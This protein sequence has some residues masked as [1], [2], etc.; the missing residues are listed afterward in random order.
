M[1]L[2]FILCESGVEAQVVR[3]LDDVG[4]PGYTRFSGAI[5]S[6]S[7]GRREGSP[8]WPGDN[9]MVI[10]GVPD[11]IVEAI[12]AGVALLQAERKGRLAIRVFAVP[13]ETLV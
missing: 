7:H 9:A 4:A 5:G 1:R 3:L 12:V 13:M 10:S 8:V 11:S 2:L 6:G